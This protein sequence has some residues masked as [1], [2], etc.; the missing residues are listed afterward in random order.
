MLKADHLD[1]VFIMSE[2]TNTT[3]KLPPIKSDTVTCS[4]CLTEIPESVAVSN[5]ADEYA[6]YF[7]GI[8]CYTRW[9]NKTEKSQTEK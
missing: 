6:Q 8:E 5:E 7:C 9:R 4:I 1:E 2:K 3:E